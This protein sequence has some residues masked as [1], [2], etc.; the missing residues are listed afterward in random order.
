MRTILAVVLLLVAVKAYGQDQKVE[1]VDPP[2]EWSADYAS[3]LVKSNQLQ[4]AQQAA[5][6]ELDAVNEKYDIPKLKRELDELTAKLNSQMGAK[7]KDCP[8]GCGFD[9]RTAKWKPNPEVVATAPET[10][11][12]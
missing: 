2:K 11:K 9:Q 10:A 7:T 8:N 3:L 6:P 5:Q 1:L 4:A 12:K